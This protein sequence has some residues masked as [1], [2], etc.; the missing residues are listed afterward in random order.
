MCCGSKGDGGSA[1]LHLDDLDV[2]GARSQEGA[3]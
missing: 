1:C 2:S 3:D